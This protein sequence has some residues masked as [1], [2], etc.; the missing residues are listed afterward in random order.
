MAEK[1]ANGSKYRLE[2]TLLN[3]L[4]IAVVYI[5]FLTLLQKLFGVAYPDLAKSASNILYGI[6][7]PAAIGSLVLTIIALWSAGGKICGGISIT[8]KAIRGCMS[9]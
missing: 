9:S 5:A 3:A 1:I 2:P 6:L 7:I 4:I 8:L